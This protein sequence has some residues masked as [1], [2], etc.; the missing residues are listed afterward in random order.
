MT[1]A[2]HGV[3]PQ[4]GT[5]YPALFFAKPPPQTFQIILIK[6]L[7]PSHHSFNLD[8]I[9]LDMWQAGGNKEGLD[10]YYLLISDQSGSCLLKLWGS[11]PHDVTPGDILRLTAANVNM[12]NGH[13]LVN[14][15][16]Q[17]KIERIG[18]ISMLFNDN[19]NY[20]FFTWKNEKGELLR[21]AAGSVR[22]SNFSKQ[23]RCTIS[24]HEDITNMRDEHLP[25]SVRRISQLRKPSQTNQRKQFYLNQFK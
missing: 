17:G 12:F 20:S 18:R 8:V 4:T 22:Q 1:Y 6:N 10:L 23:T 2:A 25:P 9:V 21:T 14:K 24:Q 16:K 3:Q 19:P 15:P 5:N 13:L 11:D 7:T